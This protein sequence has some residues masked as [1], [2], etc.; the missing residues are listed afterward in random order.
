MIKYTNY[1]YYCHLTIKYFL[2]VL[3]MY[4]S[5]CGHKNESG[6]AFCTECGKAIN[7]APQETAQQLQGYEQ[8]IR[9]QKKRVRGL[10]VGI[11]IT[12]SLLLIALILFIP[13]FVGMTDLED[14]RVTLT[15]ARAL[16]TTINMYNA[17]NPDDKMVSGV[18]LA[19]AKSKAHDLWPENIDNLE[20]SWEM[21]TIDEDGFATV[22]DSD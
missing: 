22:T 11:S 14:E 12:G 2:E 18:S 4:C 20:T 9:T 13:A 19:T 8:Q 21:V 6:A 7:Q 1:L 3:F 17:L 10:I 16:A 5:S 15:N